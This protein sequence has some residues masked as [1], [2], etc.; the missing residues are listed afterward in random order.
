[1]DVHECTPSEAVQMI[2]GQSEVQSFF[3]ETAFRT[4]SLYFGRPWFLPAVIAGTASR[5][6]SAPGRRRCLREIASPR[7]RGAAERH[8]PCSAGQRQFPEPPGRVLGQPA[9]EIAGTGLMAEAGG[10]PRP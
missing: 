5:T 4:R 6:A 8:G 10:L 3:A 7:R 9:G 2:L 1:M